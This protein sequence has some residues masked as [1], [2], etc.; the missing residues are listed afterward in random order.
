MFTCAELIVMLAV[1]IARYEILKKMKHQ[2]AKSHKKKKKVQKHGGEKR[3]FMVSILHSDAH[4]SSYFYHAFRHIFPTVSSL[5][6]KFVSYTEFLRGYLAQSIGLLLNYWDYFR[7]QGS[8]KKCLQSGNKVH[9]RPIKLSLYILLFSGCWQTSP[10]SQLWLYTSGTQL[11]GYTVW[12]TADFKSGDVITGENFLLAW[13]CLL[14][15]KSF[16][17]HFKI[18]EVIYSVS[19]EVK[20][21]QL[22]AFAA[23]IK[24]SCCNLNWPVSQRDSWRVSD[25]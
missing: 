19:S 13:R 16:N 25:T 5:E 21:A 4:L 22:C 15:Y 18:L 6:F 17:F 12:L 9:L 11:S 7:F 24:P 2:R 1:I 3:G 14:F 20:W 8:S 23:I 10:W